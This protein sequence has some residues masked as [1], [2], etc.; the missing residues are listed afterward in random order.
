VV[1]SCG[2]GS[3]LPSEGPV[4]IDTLPEAARQQ[5]EAWKAQPIKDCAWEQAFP[6]LAAQA[7]NDEPYTPLQ[8]V[9]PA[10]LLAGNQG[11]PLLVGAGGELVLLGAAGGE[12]GTRH[13]AHEERQTVN[14][15]TRSLEVSSNLDDG[16]CVVSLGGAEL[17]RTEI[18]SHLP[19]LLA[20]DRGKLTGTGSDLRA[21]RQVTLSDGQVVGAVDGG[22]V[23][24]DALAALVPDARARGF[25]AGRFGVSEAQAGVLFTAAPGARSPDTIRLVAVD[26]VSPFAPGRA[27]YGPAATLARLYNG[28][29][30]HAQLLYRGFTKDLLALDVE[31]SIAAGGKAARATDVRVA[32][33]V[34]LSDAALLT[35]FAQRRQASYFEPAQP[36]SPDFSEQFFG[37]DGLAADGYAALAADPGARQAVTRLA[38]SG[39]PAPFRGWDGA[40]IQVAERLYDRGVE[41]SVLAEP[42]LPALAPVLAHW[43]TLR[44]ALTDRKTL[45]AFAPTL[46]SLVFSW[47][48]D[49]VAPAAVLVDSVATALANTASSYG[50]SARRMLGDLGADITAQGTGAKAVRCAVALVG[51]RR[52]AVEHAL[53]TVSQVLYSA[54]FVERFRDELLQTCPDSGALAAL[55]VSS[56]A[57]SA[58]VA[59]EVA[60]SDQG[61]AF[62][63]AIR[64][65]VD[66]A[67]TEHW[68]AATFAALTDIVAFGAVSSYTACTA[69]SVSERADCM[70]SGWLA[71]TA[72]PGKMLAPGAEVRYAALARELAARWP[73]L[74]DVR[75]ADVRYEISNRVFDGL[76]LGCTP[77][78]VTRSASRLLDL[79]GALVLAPTADARFVLEQ[80]VSAL[81]GATACP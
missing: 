3:D 66:H 33:P 1:A 64:G 22:P 19:V 16:T 37:C 81:V 12:T 68:T 10:A 17:Y 57:T 54:G 75:F 20:F 48:L 59:D 76:W 45:D 34:P 43:D 73:A 78:G 55:E 13:R 14:G 5:F 50:D 39:A 15:K 77:D 62:G 51:D 9:D 23:M 61:R 47:Q 25:L 58:F 36:R 8:L 7:A 42:S 35:C 6:S 11:S 56:A 28:G 21:M 67:L 27:L 32:A 30:W 65:L 69:P 29:A 4:T 24:A 80:Q 71:L 49:G 26:D 52:A 31:L 40:M 70:D 74:A 72:R 46:I 44:A 18:A 63:D 60:R 38:M 41:L 2:G 79:L 53:A